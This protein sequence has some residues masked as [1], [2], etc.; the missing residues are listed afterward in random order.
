M[1]VYNYYSFIQK[2]IETK[3]HDIMPMDFLMMDFD[4]INMK[5]IMIFR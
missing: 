3:C 4:L 1:I 5:K 2:R